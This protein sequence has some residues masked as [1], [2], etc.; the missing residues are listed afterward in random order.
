MIIFSLLQPLVML[1]LFSQIFASIAKTP[2]FPAGVSYINYLMP[3][4]LS[5]AFI[6]FLQSFENY[7]T[8]IF[9]RGLDLNGLIHR[10][11]SLQ[12]I[13]FA[14]SKE[15][16]PCPWMDVAFAPGAHAFLEGRGGLRARIVTSGTLRLGPAEFAAVA[17]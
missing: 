4:I 15:C 7:N 2:G 10:R 1:V 5:A 12:G 17:D 11:F 13:V 3:A 8:T 9:V 14:G 6:A 16:A